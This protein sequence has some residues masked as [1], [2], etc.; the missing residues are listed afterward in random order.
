MSGGLCRENG[1]CENSLQTLISMNYS[2]L[3][4]ENTKIVNEAFW[5]RAQLG[6]SEKR[7]EKLFLLIY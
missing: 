5:C 3:K 4:P 1:S 7:F 2:R 6:V